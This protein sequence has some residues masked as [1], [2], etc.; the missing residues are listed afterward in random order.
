MSHL[1]HK[2]DLVIG[3]KFDPKT[4]CVLC[5]KKGDLVSQQTGRNKIKEVSL[6]HCLQS[7][8]LKMS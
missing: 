5:G 4:E 2:I 1:A 7:S 3:K 6:R 8:F